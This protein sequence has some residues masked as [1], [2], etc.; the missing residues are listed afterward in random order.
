MHVQRQMIQT[1]SSI[2]HYYSNDEIQCMFT[3]P[4]LHCFGFFQTFQWIG[5][6]SVTLRTDCDK[7]HALTGEKIVSQ[8]FRTNY[9]FHNFIS[10]Q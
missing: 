2:E 8:I 5:E 10:E 1:I 4:F 9:F 7:E 3:F 6:M